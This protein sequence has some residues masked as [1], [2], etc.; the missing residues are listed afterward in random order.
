ML[1]FR[2]RSALVETIQA[3]YLKNRG[4]YF[5]TAAS[6]ISHQQ[7]F[8]N[9]GFSEHITDLQPD[10]QL[11]SP[12]FKEYINPNTI[13]R[14]SEILRIAVTCSLDC[15]AQSNIKQPDAIIVGTGLGCLHE[16]EKFLDNF[17]SNDK[18]LI[19]PTAFI[20][21]THNTIGGQLSIILGNHNY[22][23]THT[24][25]ALSFE[26]SI[27]DATLSIEEGKENILVGGADE[28]IQLLNDVVEK[29]GFK[30][31]H[32]TSGASFFILSRISSENTI[33]KIIDVATYALAE[34]FSD[35][36]GTFLNQNSINI[37]EI[38]L[39]LFSCLNEQDK[40]ELKS[41]FPET[42]IFDYL[43]YIGT[44]FTNSAFAMHY[45]IDSLKHHEGK[46]KKVLICNHLHK[47]H[48]GLTLVESIET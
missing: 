29:L 8:K 11:I 24:Q 18:G 7:S 37:Q 25:N 40:E 6:S 43:K 31:L 32:L 12:N 3:W 13:R 21:S 20:Q 1:S 26:H 19:S 39:V 33:A 4:M 46:I 23:M 10:S 5:I 47:N 14:M 41:L 9:D 35:V 45:A 17:I 42:K 48:I 38:D 34:S 30:N 22:N 36:L 15:L 16:T 27:Q 2:I 44:Y 28:Y